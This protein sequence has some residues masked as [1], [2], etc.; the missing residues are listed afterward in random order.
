MTVP[1]LV[2]FLAVT[3]ATTVLVRPR[4]RPPTLSPFAASLRALGELQS[5]DRRLS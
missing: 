3:A 5:Q 2:L 4:N 1:W